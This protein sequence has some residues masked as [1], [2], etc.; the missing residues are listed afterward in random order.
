MDWRKKGMRA[1]I[2]FTLIELLVVIAIIAIIAAILLPGLK[3]AKEA[4]VATQCKNNLRQSGLGFLYYTNDYNGWIPLGNS[5]LNFKIGYHMLIGPYLDN[6]FDAAKL[7]GGGT[8]GACLPLTDVGKKTSIFQCPSSTAI[9]T[10]L[11]SSGYTQT[12]WSAYITYT[13]NRP[14]IPSIYTD[15]NHTSIYKIVPDRNFILA[16]GRSGNERGTDANAGILNAD[17]YYTPTAQ[18]CGV[19][20]QAHNNGLNA[21]FFDGH[22]EYYKTWVNFARKP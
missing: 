3:K 16:C 22:T 8:Y 15:K 9:G 6:N 19:N 20:W 12:Y 17:T 5:D 21:V 1:L 4:A 11:A 10:K 2:G 7:K 14:I 18:F 13:Y